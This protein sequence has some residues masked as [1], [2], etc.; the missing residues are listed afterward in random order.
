MNPSQYI[1]RL[2][3]HAI[4]QKTTDIY[5]LPLGDRYTVIFNGR[6]NKQIDSLKVN[7]AEQLIS[8]LCQILLIGK[9]QVMQPGSFFVPFDDNKCGRPYDQNYESRRLFVESA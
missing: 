9:N 7:E 3:N 2:L 6:E 5:I 4:Q 1:K 8:A